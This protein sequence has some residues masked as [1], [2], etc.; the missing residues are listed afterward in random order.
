MCFHRV[1]HI[2]NCGQPSVHWAHAR[3][4]LCV[5]EKREALKGGQENAGERPFTLTRRALRSCVAA[6]PACLCSLS[7][8]MRPIWP[9]FYSTRPCQN[10]LLAANQVKK[11]TS[12]RLA[13]SWGLLAVRTTNRPVMCLATTTTSALR[14]VATVA[15][16]RRPRPHR[17][18]TTTQKPKSC[19][20]IITTITFENT[21]CKPII[22]TQTH[23]LIRP[24][25]ARVLNSCRAGKRPS[26][27]WSSPTR[28][29]WASRTQSSE[30]TAVR[31]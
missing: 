11:P 8:F 21:I 16:K 18:L 5:E 31:S 3:V 14:A 28:Q 4:G 13:L 1:H 25:A 15:S 30:R 22:R 2:C 19:A 26:A 24:A 9:R 6:L 23:S 20:S 12:E 27:L 7:V 17:H 10:C 29:L